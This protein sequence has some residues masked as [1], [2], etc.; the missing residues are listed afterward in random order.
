MVS[1]DE[2]RLIALAAG[3]DRHAFELLYR[4]YFPRLA[5]FLH[6]ITRQPELIEEIVNDAMLVVW[7]KAKTYDG[8]CM[9]S[10][11]IFAIAYRTALKAL[12]NRDEA[13]PYD[14]DDE[15]AQKEHEPDA[16]VQRD[17]LREALHRALGTLSFEQRT[18]VYLTYFHDLGYEEIAAIM[19]CPVNTVKTRMFHA[20]RRLES[21]LTHWVE[22]L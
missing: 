4:C 1:L 18:V 21:L 15:P 5:R 7:Q 13:V 2:P 19:E 14:F 20:R 9:P 16:Q 6:R 12:R 22:N 8:T 10:T 17:E 3:G 11:W